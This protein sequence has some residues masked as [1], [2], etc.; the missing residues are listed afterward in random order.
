MAQDTGD[1]R[2]IRANVKVHS[3][4]QEAQQVPK[5]FLLERKDGKPVHVAIP[6]DYMPGLDD[7]FVM[8]MVPEYV[9]MVDYSPG[10]DFANFARMRA[11]WDEFIPDER[12]QDPHSAIGQMARVRYEA[13]KT[14]VEAAMRG[15]EVV[16]QGTALS[17][18]AGL[19]QRRAEVLRSYG[20]RT[21]EEFVN[22]PESM[23]M[24]AQSKMPD[25]RY[26]LNMAKAFLEAAAHNE[27]ANKLAER[28]KHIEDLKE[29]N[30]TLRSDMSE[31][32]AMLNQLLER[33]MASQTE[34]APEQQRRRGR[35]PRV[36]QHIDE[37]V[38]DEVAA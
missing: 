10:G 28:D 30:R 3:V 32:K 26:Y 31:M 14:Y 9:W 13:V 34:P 2:N 19:D 33:Q 38:A 24:S 18:W 7:E 20:I 22:A 8:K 12:A 35:Q 29:E 15:Q 5:R 25:V 4:Y 36:E 6:A 23:L 16:T 11:P 21:V 27:A 17:L 37:P 1:I